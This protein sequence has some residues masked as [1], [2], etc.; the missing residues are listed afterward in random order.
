[1]LSN[2]LF[3]PEAYNRQFIPIIHYDC[4]DKT[5]MHNISQILISEFQEVSIVGHKTLNLS[6]VKQIRYFLDSHKKTYRGKQWI[7]HNHL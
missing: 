1:M 3:L 7:E 4:I 6:G 2:S 5:N